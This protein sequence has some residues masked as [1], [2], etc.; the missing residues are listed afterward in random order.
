M[1]GEK[2]VLFAAFLLAVRIQDSLR[3]HSFI[4]ASRKVLVFMC[5]FALELGR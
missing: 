2:K 4:F 3:L 5:E 1:W